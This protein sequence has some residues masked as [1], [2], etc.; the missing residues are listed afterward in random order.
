M[1]KS[2]MPTIRRER[3]R[4]RR[5]ISSIW[6]RNYTFIKG[7]LIPWKEIWMNA[8]WYGFKSEKNWDIIG[9]RRDANDANKRN[10]KWSC[11]YFL[12]KNRREKL[13][14]PIYNHQYTTWNSNTDI[15]YH[16]KYWKKLRL[17]SAHYELPLLLDEWTLQKTWICCISIL[18]FNCFR[19]EK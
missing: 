16:M 3:N 15:T 7:S 11:C 4:W 18:M 12:T 6:K 13:I 5:R 14:A 9:M 10:Y 19:M 17:L 1:H 8:K 2:S